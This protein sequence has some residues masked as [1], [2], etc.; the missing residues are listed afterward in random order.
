MKTFCF[1]LFYLALSLFPFMAIAQTNNY[2]FKLYNNGKEIHS[3][4]I[5]KT[6]EMSQFLIDEISDFFN[7]FQIEQ[8]NSA[9]SK[10]ITTNP[11]IKYESNLA[12]YCICYMCIC[13]IAGIT[14]LVCLILLFR[15]NRSA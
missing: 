2:E 15:K 1:G 13:V 12:K 10:P 7:T 14:V 9:N 6:N 8:A 11:A 3:F 5:E 4:S